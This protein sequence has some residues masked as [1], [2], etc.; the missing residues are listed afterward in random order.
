LC[1]VAAIP[2]K[3]VLDDSISA[4]IENVPPAYD[5]TGAIDTKGIL[6][7]APGKSSVVST[8]LRNRNP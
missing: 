1:E 8:P 4:G 2:G 7:L 5:G 3:P 6:S